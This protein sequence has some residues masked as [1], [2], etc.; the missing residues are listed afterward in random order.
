MNKEQGFDLSKIGEI[1]IELDSFKGKDGVDGKVGYTPVKG[2]DYFDGKDGYTPQKGKD[3]FDG[4]NGKTPIKGIDY[5]DGKDGKDGRD[6][7]DAPIPK[8]NL[9]YFD[10]K[11]GR[12][13]V[14]G[15][16]GKDG[17]DG[18]TPTVEFATGKDFDRLKINGKV[19]GPH[20]TGPEGRIGRTHNFISGG[21]ETESDPIFKAAL[22]TDNTLSSDSDLK[23]ASQKA[24]KFYIDNR[25]PVVA[26]G[27]EVN[28]G[29]N[30][31]K[32]VTPKAMEDSDYIKGSQVPANETDPVFLDRCNRTAH[33]TG[34]PNR[35]ESILTWDDATAKLTISTADY[36]N[37]FINGVQYN[38]TVSMT[39][40]LTVAQ[41]AVSGL[42]WFW[43]ELV[44][45]VATLK[46]QISSP[47]FD[48]C[49]VATVYWNTTTNKGILSDERHWMGRDQWWHEY[50]HETIGARYYI[51]LTGTFGNTTF[52]IT[53]GE[54]YDE[55]IEHKLSSDTP[56]TYPGT[57]IT[58]CKVLYHNG[59]ADW[60]WDSAQTTPY[61]ITGAGGNLQFNTGNILS[62]AGANRFVNYF[63]FA[64]G[65]VDCPIMIVIGT[66][67]YTTLALAV[68][69]PIPALGGLA[70]AETKLL[71]KLTYRNDGVPTYQ[72]AIDYRTASNLPTDS[73]I[74]TSHASLTN[75]GMSVS[76]HTWDANVDLNG[77]NLTTTGEITAPNINAKVDF[78]VSQIFS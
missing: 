36:F 75:L 63:V 1:T 72:Q 39:K 21:L 57:A 9:D 47:G 70:S 58:T 42:Y 6:G 46:C 49:L 15:K 34:W 60:V 13:G 61:K 27:A 18:V 4:K 41:E 66:A 11:D 71:Y 54:F 22:D 32:M 62:T 65:D 59:D 3:Y 17:K 73:F 19:Q 33:Y 78:L 69:A 12:D 26:T 30:N 45:G 64:T 55:D 29:V 23:V 8:K 68:N 31:T 25:V 24:V 53:A 28:T 51:G 74:A 20:L 56:M 35:T 38:N 77:F 76:G 52:S 48:K 40:S 14:D 50:T 43:I 2:K 67:E 44:G 37:F 5:K 10:G 16:N 7:I